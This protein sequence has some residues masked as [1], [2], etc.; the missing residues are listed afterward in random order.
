MRFFNL[1]IITDSNLK[2][3]IK[4]AASAAR[5]A[6]KKE[7]GIQDIPTVIQIANHLLRRKKKRAQ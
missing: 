1:Y 5:L 6:L 7:M 3:Q 4:N 2:R